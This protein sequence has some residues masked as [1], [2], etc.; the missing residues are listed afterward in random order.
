M[1]EKTRIL[2]IDDENIVRVSC[3]RILEP[4]GFLVEL[5]ADGYEAIELIKKQPY[6]IIITDL[7]M[8]KMDGLE[9]LQWIKKNSP[10]SK[11]VVIT[12][13]STPEIAER[14]AKSGATKYLEK[15]FTPETLISVVQSAIKEG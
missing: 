14:S 13:F 1:N 8:P 3:K 5:A 10:A 2:V 15:P 6:D 4:E 9:V 7:K 12:G 11:V